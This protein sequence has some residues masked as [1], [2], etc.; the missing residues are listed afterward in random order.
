MKQLAA[1]KED[2]RAKQR[3]YD[4]RL[5]QIPEVERE[6]RRAH[7]RLREC[8]DALPRDPGQ[9]DAGRGRGGTRAGPQ[10]RALQPGRARQPAV[11]AIQAQTGRS[12]ALLGRHCIRWAA[13]WVCAWLREMFDRSVKGPLELGPHRHHPDPDAHSRTSKPDREQA[14]KRRAC[15]RDRGPVVALLCRLVPAR[16]PRVREAVADARRIG[17]EQDRGL[18]SP[19]MEKIAIAVQRALDAERREDTPLGTSNAAPIKP[20]P[21]GGL[22]AGS[23]TPARPPSRSRRTCSSATRCCRFR[24]VVVCLTLAIRN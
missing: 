8:P 13:G 3:S 22:R 15:H 2:L 20:D 14:G 10:G 11:Q 21:A 12:I 7:A 5:L 4:S 24:F 18:D 16:H 6:Y 9:A 19:N 23:S 1:T 17:G